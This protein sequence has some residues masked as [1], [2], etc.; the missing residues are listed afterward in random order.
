PQ[1][2]RSTSNDAE[3]FGTTLGVR[4]RFGSYWRW[5]AYYQYGRTEN[6]AVQNN[7]ATTIR[8]YYA[9]HAVTDN[10]AAVIVDGVEVANGHFGNPIGGVTRDGVPTLSLEGRPISDVTAL[11]ALA[12]GCQPLNLFGS[13][14]ADPEAAALQQAALNY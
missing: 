3:T 10:R 4:G 12:V 14:Y 5:D 9:T 6:Y 11:Q 13:S 7:V 8:Q 2:R 1:F